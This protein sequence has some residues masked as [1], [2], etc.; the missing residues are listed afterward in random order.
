MFFANRQREP[1]SEKDR[2]MHST[3]AGQP[4]GPASRRAGRSIVR[5]LNRSIARSTGRSTAPDHF[6]T[7][8][9]LKNRPDHFGTILGPFQHLKIN[10]QTILGCFLYHSNFKK[11][12][13]S[14]E[15]S[16]L[17]ENHNPTFTEICKKLPGRQQ[18]KAF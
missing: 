3:G 12:S 16:E 13:I 10:L 5:S 2:R 11:P 15:P 9:T 8:P 14:P 7:I 1:D 17:L 18:R 4:D 6:G